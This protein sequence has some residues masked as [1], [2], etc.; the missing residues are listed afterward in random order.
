MLHIV[1]D[2]SELP[3]NFD[4]KDES[5]ANFELGEW[6]LGYQSW[7]ETDTFWSL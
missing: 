5:G 2:C 7:L 4:F 6:E 3:L 1:A